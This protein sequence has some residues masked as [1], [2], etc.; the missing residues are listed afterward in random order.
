MKIVIN[1]R[2]GGFRLSHEAIIEYARIK[3]ITLYAYVDDRSKGADGYRPYNSEIDKNPF[4]IHYYTSDKDFSNDNYFDASDIDRSDSTLVEVVKK[5][6]DRASGKYSGLEVVEIPDDVKWQ[7]GEYDG[8]E[9]VEE[10]HR[11]WG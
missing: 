10:Q 6:G 7:I 5:M 8:M 1:K 9:W 4:C 2:Y 3:G 11:T